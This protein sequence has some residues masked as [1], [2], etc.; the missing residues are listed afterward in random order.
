ML[1]ALFLFL[2]C[3]KTQTNLTVESD[4]IQLNEEILMS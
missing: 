4:T 1:Q 2:N 3:I